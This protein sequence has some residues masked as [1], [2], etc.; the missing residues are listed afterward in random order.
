MAQYSILFSIFV[1]FSLRGVLLYEHNQWFYRFKIQVLGQVWLDIV[2]RR[3]HFRTPPL[4]RLQ[5]FRAPPL[6]R[7]QRKPV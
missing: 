1:F 7:L 5:H 4:P 3:G 6:P 2:D